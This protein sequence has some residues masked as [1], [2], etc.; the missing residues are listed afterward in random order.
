MSNPGAHTP[1]ILGQ[2]FLATAYEI[3]NYRIVSIRLIF[4]DMTRGA[5]VFNLG[6]QPKD[7]EDQTF[8]VNYIKNLTSK[9]EELEN[10]FK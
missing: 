4:G 2:P 6:K 8:K 1:V 9:H 10:E 3:I 5:N 7:L